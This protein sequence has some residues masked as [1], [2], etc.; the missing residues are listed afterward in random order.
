VSYGSGRCGSGCPEKEERTGKVAQ[1][2]KKKVTIQEFLGNQK[3]KFETEVHVV[4]D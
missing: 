4:A 2:I 3:L 1:V